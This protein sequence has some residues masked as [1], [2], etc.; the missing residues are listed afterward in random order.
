MCCL[1]YCFFFLLM[2]ETKFR[3]AHP[4]KPCLPPSFCFY[5]SLLLKYFAC[6]FPF[7]LQMHLRWV[8]WSCWGCP[9]E[10]GVTDGG[11]AVLAVALCVSGLGTGFSE[12]WDRADSMQ[13][14][15]WMP[16]QTAQACLIQ[17][18]LPKCPSCPVRPTC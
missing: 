2:P 6:L 8:S 16:C 7:G 12:V 17:K 3:I 5:L 11:Y 1:L 13:I 4:A 14:V 10:V 15:L 9:R 18:E